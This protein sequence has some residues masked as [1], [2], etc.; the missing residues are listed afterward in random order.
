MQKRDTPFNWEC[1]SCRGHATIGG[2]NIKYYANLIEVPNKLGEQSIQ[3]EVIGCPNSECGE[4]SIRA[5]IR[6]VRQNTRGGPWTVTTGYLEEWTLRP[7]SDAKPMPACVPEPIANDYR[8]AHLIRDLSPKASAT[9]SRRCL[10]GMIRNFWEVSKG[11]LKEEIDAIQGDVDPDVWESIEAVR[12]VGNIG[13]HMDAD[14]NVVV[15]VE[16][17]EATLLLELIETLVQDWYV[18]RETRKTRLAAVQAL[19][20][21]KA[22][23]KAQAKK[24]VAKN[25]AVAKS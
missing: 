2:A 15:D 9:L 11:T 22:D 10:Q 5:G 19:A 25:P 13:A 18:Q 7:R 1:P 14:I 24:A 16:P 23:E 12:R 6:R 3:V 8:E 17:E 20:K 4:L 21:A